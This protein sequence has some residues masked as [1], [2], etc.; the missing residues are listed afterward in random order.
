MASLVE[1][2][3]S[4]TWYLSFVGDST[5][6]AAVSVSSPNTSTVTVIL[7]GTSQWFWSAIPAYLLTAPHDLSSLT[8]AQGVVAVT[9]R[10]LAAFV[11]PGSGVVTPFI[12]S[13]TFAAPNSCSVLP[14]ELAT[15][16]LQVN[17]TSSAFLV[18]NPTAD[19]VSYNG[20]YS[21]LG[22]ALTMNTSTVYS[23]IAPSTLPSS[24]YAVYLNQGPY[25]RIL[26]GSVVQG[27]QA[28]LISPTTGTCYG[29][30]RLTVTGSNFPTS[31]TGFSIFIGGAPCNPF[32]ATTSTIQCR[33]TA[34]LATPTETP[35]STAATATT[36]F[37]RMY[38]NQTNIPSELAASYTSYAPFGGS[39]APRFSYSLT[40]VPFISGISPSSGGGGSRNTVT[41][42]GA[43]FT[44]VS[45][46]MCNANITSC[47]PIVCP[48]ATFTATQVVCTT[49]LLPPATYLVIGRITA[50]GRTNM[51]I[52]Y[53]SIMYVDSTSPLYLS[54]TG[55]SSVTITG[56]GF[57]AGV[58]VKIGSANCIVSSVNATMI[59]CKTDG[60][61]V[62]LSAVPIVYLPTI[63]VRSALV[64]NTTGV[65]IQGRKS[66]LRRLRGCGC[67]PYFYPSSGNGV[68]TTI[69]IAAANFPSS[70]T[71][72]SMVVVM[73]GDTPSLC[74]N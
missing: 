14:L 48:S 44:G 55:G 43:A 4:C 38:A 74:K 11:V 59:N 25:G 52:T 12:V 37:V 3:S 57:G 69:T 40:S 60:D 7:Q 16:S 24:A 32:Y 45:F 23:V 62:E 65:E 15:V 9:S 61:I 36:F 19:F 53:T 51:N 31:F 63:A 41:I 71:D 22:N 35:V 30:T 26:C 70:V 13:A 17:I 21:S 6:Q 2:A 47:S 18:A 64:P 66:R 20:L 8:S 72:P 1:T 39:L 49:P 54:P 46:S 27:F 67:V 50:T 29:G 56:N 58:T 28:I 68:G 42:T 73:I 5:P 34:M 33:T 10:G